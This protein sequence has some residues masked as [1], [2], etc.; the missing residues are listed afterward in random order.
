[1]Q[2]PKRL[3]FRLHFD[4]KKDDF[5]EYTIEANDEI[6]SYTEY[7]VTLYVNGT[8]LFYEKILVENEEDAHQHAETMYENYLEY[9]KSWNQQKKKN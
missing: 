1:M 3:L 8:D 5:F 6:A 4:Y 7:I 9:I 2:K